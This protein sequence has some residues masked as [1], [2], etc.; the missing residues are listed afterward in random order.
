MIFFSM[1]EI[2]TFIIH[3]ILENGESEDGGLLRSDIINWYLEK[4]EDQIN[5]ESELLEKKS[6]IEKVLDRLIHNVSSLLICMSIHFY[7]A[8]L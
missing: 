2:Y 6:F 7:K 3:C 1:T 4:I 5:D 8:I